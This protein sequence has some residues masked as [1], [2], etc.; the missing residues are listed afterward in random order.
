MKNLST[1]NSF[2]EDVWPALVFHLRHVYFERSQQLDGNVV[3]CAENVVGCTDEGKDGESAF[4]MGRV[5]GVQAAE[6]PHLK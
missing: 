4:V 5:V 3:A 1:A 2:F 6:N